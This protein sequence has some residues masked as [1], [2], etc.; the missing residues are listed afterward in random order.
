MVPSWS[1]RS[2]RLD[3][4]RG[5]G[6]PL[7]TVSQRTPPLAGFTDEGRI[8]TKGSVPCV[9]RQ[10]IRIDVDFALWDRPT[11]L[12]GLDRLHAPGIRVV[13]VQAGDPVALLL[14]V[15]THLI[16]PAFR[17]VRQLQVTFGEDGI[18]HRHLVERPRIVGRTGAVLGTGTVAGPGTD[19]VDV[20]GR[21]AGV[22]ELIL[23]FGVDENRLGEAIQRDVHIALTAIR[24]VV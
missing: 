12:V 19:H 23:R 20:L 21:D 1:A 2:T 18:A 13:V 16:E 14:R 5:A 8:V 4:A 9:V 7:S 22:A 11:L 15:A 3:T 24:A 10:E 6:V 17:L